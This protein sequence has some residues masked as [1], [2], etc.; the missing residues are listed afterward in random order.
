MR[1]LSAGRT[2]LIAVIFIGAVCSWAIVAW[3]DATLAPGAGGVWLA[4]TVLIGG[5]AVRLRQGRTP[6]A[7][8]TGPRLRPLQ[9]SCFGAIALGV[10]LLHAAETGLLTAAIP[11]LAAPWLPAACI[12][13]GVGGLAILSFG[14]DCRNAAFSGEPSEEQKRGVT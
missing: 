11:A 13:G 6:S 2:P 12:I 14:S 8:A 4:L 9:V 10:H 3:L 7:C 1:L 5:V